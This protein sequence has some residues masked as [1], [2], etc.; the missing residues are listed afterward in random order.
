MTLYV[1]D[2][3]KRD[4]AIAQ[5]ALDKCSGSTGRWLAANEL[6]ALLREFFDATTSQKLIAQKV[7]TA[8][9]VTGDSPPNPLPPGPSRADQ[10]TP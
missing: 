6:A 10:E 4:A 2:T 9:G 5:F 1:F 8:A 7:G 3:S